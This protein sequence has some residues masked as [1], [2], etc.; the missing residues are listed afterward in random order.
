MVR[1]H[2][3]QVT[4]FIWL[5]VLIGYTFSAPAEVWHDD[6]D[7]ENLEAWQSV[8]NDAIWK[9]TDGFLRVE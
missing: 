8:G 7:A 9:V 2:K 4:L 1:L 6:F 5:Y 3:N